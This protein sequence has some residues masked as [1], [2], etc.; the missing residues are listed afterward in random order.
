MIT[1]EVVEEVG[2]AVL[3]LLSS[4]LHRGEAE[5]VDRSDQARGGGAGG[6]TLG[7]AP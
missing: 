3:G 5:A 2:G 4:R 6:E 1:L 7:F